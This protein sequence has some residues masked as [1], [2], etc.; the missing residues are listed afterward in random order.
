MTTLSRTLGPE[1]RAHMAL[2][3]ARKYLQPPK[4]YSVSVS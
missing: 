3:S 4:R 1:L 2:L